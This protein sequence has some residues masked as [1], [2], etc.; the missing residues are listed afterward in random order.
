[1]KKVDYTVGKRTAMDGKTW[2]TCFYKNDF[3]NELRSIG[4]FKTKKEA[5]FFKERFL[6]KQ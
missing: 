1:M 5:N 6:D 4:K 3:T 2:W